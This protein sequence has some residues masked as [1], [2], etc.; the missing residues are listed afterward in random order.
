MLQKIIKLLFTLKRRYID[1]Q[2]HIL[3]WVQRRSL[4]KYAKLLGYNYKSSDWYKASYKVFNKDYEFSVKKFEQIKKGTKTLYLEDL[5]ES[6]KI[7]LIN[8]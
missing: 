5:L 7:F 2:R 6:L 3:Y 1:Q 8:G 4:K